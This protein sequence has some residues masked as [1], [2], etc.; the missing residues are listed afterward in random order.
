[1]NDFSHVIVYVW[2]VYNKEYETFI[3][4]TKLYLKAQ[5]VYKTL[6]NV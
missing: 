5:L 4:K 3:T 1:M 2:W 6:M